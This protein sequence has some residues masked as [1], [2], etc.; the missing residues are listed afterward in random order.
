MLTFHL[1]LIFVD[2]SFALLA[3]E[4]AVYIVEG[5]KEDVCYHHPKGRWSRGAY[6]V[7]HHWFYATLHLIATFLFMLLVAPNT[8]AA[9]SPIKFTVSSTN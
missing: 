3:Q 1:V 6:F 5:E 2:S 4:A 9:N 8:V 7:L